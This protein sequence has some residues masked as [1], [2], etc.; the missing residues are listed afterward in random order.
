MLRRSVRCCFMCDRQKSGKPIVLRCRSRLR[1][2][3][4]FISERNNSN[5]IVPTIRPRPL[6]TALFCMSCSGRFLVFRDLNLFATD[7]STERSDPP[8]SRKVCFS[9][10]YPVNRR[11]FIYVSTISTIIRRKEATIQLSDR[12]G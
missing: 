10:F 6:S 2:V 8:L 11:D 1:R 12:S 3:I 7:A 4:D 9:S 5:I